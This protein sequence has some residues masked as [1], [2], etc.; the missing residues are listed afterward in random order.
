MGS[1]CSFVLLR[2]NLI[3]V[4]CSQELAGTIQA[5]IAAV[6]LGTMIGL[7]VSHN[8]KR[9][10]VAPLMRIPFVVSWRTSEEEEH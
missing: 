3:I 5:V 1:R 8:T 6:A 4:H 2:K 10:R 7:L 9:Y